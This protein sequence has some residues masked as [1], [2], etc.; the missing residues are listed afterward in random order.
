M[1]KDVINYIW[2]DKKRT[3]FG[4]PISF[5]RYFLTEDK[6]ITRKGFLSIEEDELDLYRVIDKKLVLPLGQRM[7]GCG[8]IVMN[9]KDVDTPV[10][11]VKSIK[12]PRDVLAQL[13][14]YIDINRD[15]YRVR[16]RDM[17]GGDGGHC[18]DHDDFDIDDDI[19]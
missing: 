6:F 4:L 8:T 17:V 10:K 13:D 7:F 19:I 2:T 18:H 9:V 11:E 14:K 16:G 3:I 12:A 15:R 5:T 1:K